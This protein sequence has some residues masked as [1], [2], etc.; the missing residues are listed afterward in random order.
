MLKLP[1]SRLHVQKVYIRTLCED[2]GNKLGVGACISCLVRTRSGP[3]VIGNSATLEE[4][5]ECVLSGKL[6]EVLTPIDECFQYMPIA[7]LS[8]EDRNFFVKGNYLFGD[9][10]YLEDYT[11]EHVRVYN[12]GDF[13]GIAVVK[14]DKNQIA[15]KVLKSLN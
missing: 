13:L 2:I 12:F 4:I 6:E 15:L 5:Q 9:F 11:G 1:L 7:R 8:R 10:N 14:K 3:F